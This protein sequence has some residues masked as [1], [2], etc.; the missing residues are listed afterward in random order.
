M[1]LLDLF[2]GAGGAAA[3]YHRAGFTEIVGV[4]IK[5]QRRYPF[6]FVRGD[7]LEIIAKLIED[8]DYL[9]P[10]FDAVHASPPCQ[11]YSWAAKRWKDRDRADLVE[12]TRELLIRLGLPWVM[13]NVIG[14]P[15]KRAT[16][17]SAGHSSGSKSCAIGALS[18][19]NC[20]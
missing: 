19:Q 20:S 4:D 10:R 2:C 1:R 16:S 6:T 18:R 11:K 12:P 8:P 15:L 17:R 7:A 9:G 3:G 14:A 13:E 5:W